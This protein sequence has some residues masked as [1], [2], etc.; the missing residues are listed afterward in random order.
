[1]DGLDLYPFDPNC[2]GIRFDHTCHHEVFFFV[3]W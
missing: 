2:R 3:G 1:M